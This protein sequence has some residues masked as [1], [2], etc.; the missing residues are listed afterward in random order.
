MGTDIP[1]TDNIKTK[2]DMMDDH[3]I[4][5]AAQESVKYVVMNH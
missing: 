5:V 1:T 3:N 4:P 2:S